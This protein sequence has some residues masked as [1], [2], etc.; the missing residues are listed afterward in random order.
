MRRWQLNAAALGIALVAVTALPRTA[1]A[2]ADGPDGLVT[3]GDLVAA[4]MR[5][6]SAAAQNPKATAA[7]VRAASLRARLREGDFQ[8]GDRIV[9]TILSDSLR[10]D[11]VTVRAG[12]IIEL[13]GK[14]SVPLEGVLR[15]ELQDRVAGEVLKL[16][17]AERVEAV[18]LTRIGVLGEVLRP[19]YFALA[20]DTPLTDAIMSAGGPSS[21]ADMERSEV[22][23]DGKE[24]R[25]NKLT[26]EAISRG[27]TIEQFGL[28]PGD[29]LFV[30]RRRDFNPGP[31]VTIIGGVAS[32]VTV[33]L[34]VHH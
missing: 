2:Q 34:A 8:V 15:S 16:V 3:R 14:M 20:W 29:E 11:T 28:R 17:R 23:R 32:L 19:G 7:A 9:V 33:Y 13:P 5:A 1:I 26:R 22:K 24:F 10:R 30:G 12:R 4:V 31:V 21:N 27:L 6:D 18:P 25:S